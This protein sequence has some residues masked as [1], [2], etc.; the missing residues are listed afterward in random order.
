MAAFSFAPAS[1]ADE[2]PWGAV[3]RLEI[4]DAGQCT[5][6]VVKSTNRT[7]W[8]DGD[9]GDQVQY[10]DW[11]VTAGHCV[12]G[13]SF[14]FRAAG[15]GESASGGTVLGMSGPSQHDI[16]VLRFWT[17]TK[18][19][20]LEPAMDYKA[21][22]GEPLTIVSYGGGALMARVGPFAGYEEHTGDLMVSSYASKGS[23]GGPVLIAGTQRVVGI[24]TG[25]VPDIPKNV[26]PRNW[27][28]YCIL[29]GCAPKPPYYATSIDYLK[30]LV[31]WRR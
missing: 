7:A 19:Q 27:Q 21:E 9:E 14:T 30:G 17:A 16:A 29:A 26:S 15:G 3:G 11:V 20:T 22:I 4:D 6:F 25:A 23:S 18:Y 12:H 13:S 8:N 24:V 28:V 10:E 2:F 31:I 1:P 5:G